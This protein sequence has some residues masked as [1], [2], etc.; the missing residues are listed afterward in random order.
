LSLLLLVLYSVANAGIGV[1]VG[2]AIPMAYS[3]N[4]VATLTA[5]IWFLR[6]LTMIS[7]IFY[8]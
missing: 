6:Y 4:I 2:T 3:A 8:P 5:R 1:R 7:V